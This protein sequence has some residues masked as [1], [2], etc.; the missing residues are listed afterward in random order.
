MIPG[1]SNN[2]GVEN[3]GNIIRFPDKKDKIGI[4]FVGEP[5]TNINLISKSDSS[6]ALKA[7]LNV[8]LLDLREQ[9]NSSLFAKELSEFSNNKANSFYINSADGGEDNKVKI[10]L[11]KK[12]DRAMKTLTASGFQDS[13][14]NAYAKQTNTSLFNDIEA[15]V[16]DPLIGQ[17]SKIDESLSDI[18][19]L[20]KIDQT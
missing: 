13:E 3:R 11:L 16:R 15:L 9:V 14:V 1:G 18:A 10:D 5:E 4:E 2:P 6:I 20:L 19:E 12:V 17:N 8:K 7:K